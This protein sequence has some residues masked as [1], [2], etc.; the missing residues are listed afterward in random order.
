MVT[1][2]IDLRCIACDGVDLVTKEIDGQEMVVCNFC[3]NRLSLEAL[4]QKIDKEYNEF[5]EKGIEAITYKKSGWF[6]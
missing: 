4:K 1:I 5:Q 3:D 2:K 6:M